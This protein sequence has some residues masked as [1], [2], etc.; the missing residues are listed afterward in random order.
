MN[1]EIFHDSNLL[2]EQDECEEPVEIMTEI[3]DVDPSKKYIGQC[4][5][6]NNSYGYGFITIWEGSHKGTDIFVHHTGIQPL[7]SNYK[8]LKKGEYVAF[9]IAKGDK[10]QQAVDVTGINDGPLMCDHV[11]IK[12][13]PAPGFEEQVD[14]NWNTVTY[15]RKSSVPVSIQ[16]GFKRRRNIQDV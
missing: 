11:N 9:N 7:N 14:S 10:G 4:K 5:W 15:N 2:C 12:K 3:V 6:F 13:T 8:T 16:T 1:T